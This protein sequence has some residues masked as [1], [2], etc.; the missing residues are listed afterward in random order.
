MGEQ[1]AAG[2]ASDED[3]KVSHTVLNCT[4]LSTLQ[5]V[6][7]WVEME[8]PSRCHMCEG[9]DTILRVNKLQ[10]NL[11]GSAL[12]GYMGLIIALSIDH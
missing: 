1:R 3:N 5:D 4:G 6:L 8:N 10:H 12:N 11:I 2:P 7:N 9:R